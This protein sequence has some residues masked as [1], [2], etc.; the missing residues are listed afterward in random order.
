MHTAICLILRVTAHSQD[1]YECSGHLQIFL[2]TAA[3]GFRTR[4]EDQKHILI[5][6]SSTQSREFDLRR[7]G[8]HMLPGNNQLK[9]CR[10]VCDMEAY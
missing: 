6:V 8:I 1:A 9:L 7:S 10:S 3:G 4:G 2:P 5:I